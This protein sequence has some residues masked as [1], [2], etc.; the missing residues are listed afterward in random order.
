MLRNLRLA[1]AVYVVVACGGATAQDAA[2][3]FR[4]PDGKRVAVSLSFD[5]A[6][7][8]QVDVGVPMLDKHGVKATFYVNPHSMQKR[9]DLWKKV[10]ANG[11]EIASHSDSHPCTAN[12]A[13]SRHNALEDYTL[14]KM[15]KELDD[16]TATLVRMM[17]IKPATFAF[18]CGQKFVGRGA[19]VK[20]YVPLV[21]KRFL[22]SRG[23]RDESAND[24][25]VVDLAQI[26]GVES[27]GLSFDQ[28]KGMAIEAA[29]QARWLVFAGH[30]IGAPGRQTTRSDALEPFL[31]FA[32]DPANGIWLDTVEKVARYIQLQRSKH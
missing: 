8:S 20:S 32:K 4:W 17:G 14:S 25:T 10:A 29:G 5:D 12:Y 11:H 9:L 18:P 16:T 23:F 26:L 7:A 27:D 3:R 6:R 28:M 24:P 21:A 30:E 1:S 15:E 22:A 2:G 13:F 19:E 31:E